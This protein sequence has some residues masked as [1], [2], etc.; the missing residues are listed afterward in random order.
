VTPDRRLGGRETPL[1]YGVPKPM[2]SARPPVPRRSDQPL[3]RPRGGDR[4][5]GTRGRTGCRRRRSPWATSCPGPGRS[6][7]DGCGICIGVVDFCFVLNMA[8]QFSMGILDG[9]V[10]PERGPADLLRVVAVVT[11]GL[12]SSRCGSGSG[13]RSSC[14]GLAAGRSPLRRRLP[15]GPYML[16]VS[17]SSPRVRPG[18]RRGR[19]PGA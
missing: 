5:G 17:V 4:P 3:C 10:K 1:T 13:R 9:A 11:I 7:R 18:P 16:P 19:R 2:S 14:S 8:G 12:I 6:S 15:G